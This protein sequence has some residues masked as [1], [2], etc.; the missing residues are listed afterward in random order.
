MNL[1]AAATG[2]ADNP[3][4]YLSRSTGIAAFLLLTATTTTFGVAATQRAL[5]SRAWPRFAT[6][7]LHRNLALLGVGFL[8]VHILSTLLDSYVTV[9]WYALIVPGL[10]AYRR[11][12]VALGTTAWDLLVLLALTS[13][14]RTRLPAALWRA[15]H[16]S[17]YAAWLLALLHFLNTGTDA[18]YH[19]WGVWLGAACLVVVAA[20]ARRA[21]AERNR[22]GLDPVRVAVREIPP[23]YV[24]SEESAAVYWLNGGAAK[25]TFT[26]PRPFEQGVDKRPT[27]VNNVETLAQ[28][29]LLA[30]YGPDW[31]RAVG[32]PEQPGTMLLTV[33]GPP[34]PPRVVEVP[35]GAPLQAV[36]DACGTPG[37]PYQAVLVGGY[38]GTWLPAAHARTLSLTSSALAAAGG[39]LGAGILFGLPAESCG[40]AETARVAGYLAAQSAGQ[41]GPC[42]RGLPAIAGALH[43]LA[44][45]PWEEALA[46]HLDRRLAVVP[47]RG[48]CR[49]PDGAVRFVASGLSVF[50]DDVAAHRGGRPCRYAPARP[51]LPLPMAAPG[52]WR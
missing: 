47:G 13:L 35:T 42:I 12:W 25:P 45:G 15:V 50:A 17:S 37:E 23:W 10:S 39:A 33:T 31:F 5:A 29:A 38:F 7:A 40:V 28:V 36:L 4:W 43:R 20:A 44:F 32:D 6:Q 2:F 19:R 16:W 24:A 51:W 34:A 9:G 22:V 46:S 30:R 14:L 8:A 41:C 27:L 18:A 52:S 21:V 3:L 1:T 11:P 48:A 26:P 49:H